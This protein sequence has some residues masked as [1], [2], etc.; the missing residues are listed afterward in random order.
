MAAPQV[1]RGSYWEK[2]P[3]FALI[4]DKIH[5]QRYPLVGKLYTIV[6]SPDSYP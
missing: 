2:N 5:F 3:E 6:F 4:L 1:Q